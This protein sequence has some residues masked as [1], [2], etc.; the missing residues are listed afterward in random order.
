MKVKVDYTPNKKQALFHSSS[1][2]ECVYGGAKGGGKSCALTLECLAYCLEHPGCD[3]YLFRETYDNLEANII[4]EW[5]EKVPSELY[6]YIGS[7][8]MATLKNGS[9]VRFRYMSSDDEAEVYQGRSMDFVGVDELTKHSEKA[10][11]ILLSCLRSAKGFKTVF[12]ATCNPGGKG[13]AW[14]KKRYV[15]ATQHG[16]ITYV[17][18]VS[19]N[20]VQFI[21]AT[22]YDNDILMEN[23]PAYVRRLENLPD[24]ERK[25]FLLGDWDIFEGQYFA[26]WDYAKHT[27]EPFPI[28]K[29]W[30]VYRTMDYGLDCFAMLWIACDDVGGVYVFREFA[31]SDMTISAAAAKANELTDE[32]VYDTLAP[33]DLWGRS[34]ETGRSKALLFD[35]AGLR[36]NKSNNDREAGW[37]AIRELLKVNEDGFARLKIFRTCTRLIADLPQLQHDEKKPT[38]CAVEPHDITHVP[39]ALRY[40]AIAWTQPAEALPKAKVYKLPFALRTAEDE[41]DDTDNELGIDW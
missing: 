27:C 6:T 5:K 24:A 35:E 13:H 26:E 38:D 12:R 9:T 39:D 37:L 1:A 14:V 23:D 20:K 19:G 25:A 10:I 15:E 36:L 11:Q 41:Y 33:P 16:R 17:D 29:E 30:K 8:H 4:K 18:E 21:P 22:V 32:L 31:Q 28:P 34:Q 7:K 40:F 3:A 2:Q